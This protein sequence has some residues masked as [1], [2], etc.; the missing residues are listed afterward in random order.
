[1]RRADRL[2]DIIQL[3]RGAARPMT[4][5]TLAARLE[6]SARTVYRDI[7]CLQGSGVPI[8]GAAGLGYVLRPG[9]DLPPLMFTTEEAQ[10]IAVALDLLRRTGDRGLQEA[11]DRVRGKIAAVVP[12]DLRIGEAPFH[13]SSYGAQVPDVVCMSEVR[14]AIRT[15]RK[16]H[17]DYLDRQGRRSA[18]VIWPI[19]VAYFVEATLIGAWCELRGDYRH[20]R[21]DGVR[22][23]AV[24]D[25][26][27]PA[28]SPALLAGWRALQEQGRPSA[29]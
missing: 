14:D 12:P 24:L 11:A 25:N 1:M 29:V 26:F 18:R 6:V 16:L 10:S 28:D 5:A 3:L 20:F 19:A 17:I 22:A 15:S 4:A 7:A 8:D 13:V 21:V 9:F 27:H 2:F 23:M